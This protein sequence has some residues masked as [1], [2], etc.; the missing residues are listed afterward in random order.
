M[1]PFK[2]MYNMSMLRHRFS[3]ERW[4]EGG[5]GGGGRPEPPSSLTLEV[6]LLC[7]K[8]SFKTVASKELYILLHLVLMLCHICVNIC[9]RVHSTTSFTSSLSNLLQSTKN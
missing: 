5:G 7:L 3:N 6:C 9:L 1:I 2:M 8:I 4:R